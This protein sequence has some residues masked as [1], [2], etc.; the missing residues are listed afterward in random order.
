MVRF[1]ILALLRNLLYYNCYLDIVQEVASKGLALVY[2]L[3]NDSQKQNL[4]DYLVH[5]LMEGKR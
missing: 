4:V 5:T 2:E 1:I 3:S